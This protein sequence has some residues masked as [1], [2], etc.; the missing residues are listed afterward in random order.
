MSVMCETQESLN[1]SI[2]NSNNLGSEYI[3]SILH[4]IVETVRSGDNIVAICNNIEYEFLLPFTPSNTH[5]RFAGNTSKTISTILCDCNRNDALDTIIVAVPEAIAKKGKFCSFIPE[6]DEQTATNAAI[7][8]SA[9]RGE[10]TNN[11][12]LESMKQKRLALINSDFYKYEY[13]IPATRIKKLGGL[14]FFKQNAEEIANVA[15]AML[16][17]RTQ[18]TSEVGKKMVTCFC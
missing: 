8:F 16:E 6:P 15:E 1:K 2:Q 9:E 12:I 3:N 10:M 7:A 17:G 5:Q 11:D 14:K 18:F 4:N 13:P